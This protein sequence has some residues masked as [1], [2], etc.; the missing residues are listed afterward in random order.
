MSDQG[1][2]VA[3]RQPAANPT[4][5]AAGGGGFPLEEEL[6]TFLSMKPRQWVRQLLSLGIVLIGALMMWK[7]LMLAVNSESPIV[8]VLSGS[9]EPGYYRSDMLVLTLL[10]DPVTVGDI[11][12]FKQDGR[13]IP[14]VH[15]VHRVHRTNLTVENRIK[16][17]EDGDREVNPELHILTKGDNN[18]HDDRV[19]Y[20]NNKVWIHEDNLMGRSRAYLPFVG[21]LTILVSE[22]LWLKYVILGFMAFFVLSAKED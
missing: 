2:G 16:K 10:S 19:L 18:M 4:A 13:Q 6:R 12:V 9:M 11:C 17:P 15:R 21:W 14:I 7:S 22:N 1:R 8:V 3:A 20:E 5:A